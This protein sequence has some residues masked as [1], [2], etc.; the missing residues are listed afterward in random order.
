MPAFLFIV[1]QSDEGLYRYLAD[2]FADDGE[3]EVVL[4]RRHGDRRLG[5]SAPDPERRRRER[6]RAAGAETFRSLGFQ[7]VPAGEGKTGVSQLPH[8]GETLD[9]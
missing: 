2:H 6:R 5:S 7:V 9:T 4:D 8:S 1:A 3:V